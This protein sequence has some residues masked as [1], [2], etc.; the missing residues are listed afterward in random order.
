MWELTKHLWRDEVGSSQSTE[1]ALV[2]GVTIGA[3]VMG[4]RSFGN[5]V[6][7]RF[8][9]IEI[10][11]DSLAQMQLRMEQERDLKEMTEEQRFEKLRQRRQEQIERRKQQEA[12]QAVDADSGT[13]E[14]AV[15]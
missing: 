7:S 6:N 3:L 2:T 15:N 1:M 11:D 10:Q 5:A 4:M 14:P 12:E 9:E 8:E 13:E